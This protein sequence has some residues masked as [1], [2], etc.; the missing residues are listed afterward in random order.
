MK[1]VRSPADTAEQGRPLTRGTL[2]DGHPEVRPE[3]RTRQE[4]GS[5]L[6]IILPSNGAKSDVLSLIHC[7]ADQKVLTFSAKVPMKHR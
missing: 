3:A 2:P 5:R 7:Q 6:A 4:Y 1:Q